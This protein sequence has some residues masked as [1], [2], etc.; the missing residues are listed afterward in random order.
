MARPK[1]PLKEIKTRSCRDENGKSLKIGMV[2][3][4]KENIL[5]THYY[6]DVR[7]R[8]KMSSTALPNHKIR[9]IAKDIN[10]AISRWVLDNPEGFRMPLDM[11]QLAISKFIL[12]PFRE[13]RYEIINRIKNLTTE[14][15]SE[16]FRQTVLRKYGQNLDKK[17]I[18]AF[19]AQGKT[20]AVPMWFNH[21][22][23]SI[24]KA[25]VFKWKAS[26]KLR[27]ELKT[28][29]RTKYYHLNFHD[30][31]ENRIKALDTYLD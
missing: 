5:H 1:E 27:K 20:V 14:E 11:G 8:V 10:R 2:L 30:Y 26:N 9:K 4:K 6:S 28:T 22:N 13:D 24:R 7:K 25:T 31:H 21:R 19:M 16:R 3:I 23:C 12:I 15:I 29:D 17:T 18:T